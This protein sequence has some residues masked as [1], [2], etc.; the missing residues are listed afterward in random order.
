MGVLRVQL[1]ENVVVQTIHFA[2]IRYKITCAVMISCI[3]Y[4]LGLEF[5]SEAMFFK[6]DYE[7]SLSKLSAR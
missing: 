6:G 3:Q 7:K 2:S 4:L 5:E 1:Q